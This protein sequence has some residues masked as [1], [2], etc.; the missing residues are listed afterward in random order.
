MPDDIH[1]DLVLDRFWDALVDDPM[2]D[3]I[4]LDPQATI[5]LRQLHA[6]ASAPPPA[7]SRERVRH[8]LTGL[9]GADYEHAAPPADHSMPLLFIQRHAAA[10]DD[11]STMP[12]ARSLAAPQATHGARR[13]TAILATAAIALFALAA[14]IPTLS[15][16]LLGNGG[17][18]PR[19]RRR[20][21][22][23]HKQVRRWLPWS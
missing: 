11:H 1:A 6:V 2:A 14:S 5:S 17:K 7:V 3:S 13:W 18:V 20:P 22:K 12:T 16:N 23:P 21:P 4:D 10:A 19:S 9:P 15:P 8:R